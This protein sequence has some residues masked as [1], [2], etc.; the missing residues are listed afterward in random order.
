MRYHTI[1]YLYPLWIKGRLERLE[2]TKGL[3]FLRLPPS[4]LVTVTLSLTQYLVYATQA[5]T[6]PAP[7]VPRGLALRAS[8]LR[9]KECAERAL[10]VGVLWLSQLARYTSSFVS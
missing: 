2:P 1:R 8:P 4:Y 7:L 9:L 3:V 6:D 5:F 10:D